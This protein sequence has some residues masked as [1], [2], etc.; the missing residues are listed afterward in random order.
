[1]FT[2]EIFYGIAPYIWSLLGFLLVFRDTYADDFQSQKYLKFLYVIL[3]ATPTWEIVGVL[4]L[5]FIQQKYLFNLNLTYEYQYI[6]TAILYSVL[7]IAPIPLQARLF[8]KK[9]ETSFSTAVISYLMMFATESLAHFIGKTP[10]SSFVVYVIAS[11]YCFLMTRKYIVFLSDH[12][13]TRKST[14]AVI[15]FASVCFIISSL[16]ELDIYRT[17]SGTHYSDTEVF[18][19]YFIAV[20][21]FIAMVF[22]HRTDIKY[23]QYSILRENEAREKEKYIERYTQAQYET[24]QSLAEISEAKSGETGKHVQR[25]SEYTVIL[26]KALGVD[27]KQLQ[28]LKT[29]SM[30]HDVGKLLIPN[31]I[32]EK[33]G[34]LTNEEFEVIKTHTNYGF[35]LL[36]NSKGPIMQ[37]ARII[38]YEHHE[39]WDGTGYPQGL[40]KHHIHLYAQ[41][42]SVADVFD[43][44]TSKRCYKEAWPIEKARQEIISLSGSSFSPEVVNAFD[45]NFEAFRIVYEQNKDTGE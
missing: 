33:P 31:E 25:V 12:K 44:L 1:M 28:I 4:V 3:Y 43:A 39:K 23:H 18:W 36:K 35:N 17:Y 11:A 30:L 2:K 5:Y 29:A 7:F 15:F 14:S 27:E 16:Y 20:L 32:L 45:K 6:M 42:V 41:I 38:A 8:A 9:F 10:L 19:Y 26:A 34:K 13:S 37:F 24:I 40:K 22:F 21:V